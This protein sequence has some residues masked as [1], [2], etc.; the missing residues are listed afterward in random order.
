MI[1]KIFSFCFVIHIVASQNI[2]PNKV[3][4]I[5]A[6]FNESRD[7]I[8]EGTNLLNVSLCF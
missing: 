5:H 1:L 2:L 8:T 4:T 7:I 6:I 3:Q